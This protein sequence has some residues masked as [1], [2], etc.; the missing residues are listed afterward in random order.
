M[1]TIDE[2]TQQEMWSEYAEDFKAL[3]CLDEAE[4][5]FRQSEF[6]EGPQDT[7]VRLGY[8]LI[9]REYESSMRNT[10]GNDKRVL[11]DPTEGYW[12]N[13]VRAYEERD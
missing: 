9:M 12:S 3:D 8:L 1:G 7:D 13:V 2:E 11:R 5:V 6:L 4:E 10:A